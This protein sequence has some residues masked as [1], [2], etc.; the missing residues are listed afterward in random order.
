M[1]S[2]EI[3]V[4]STTRAIGMMLS[5]PTT[6]TLRSDGR[7]ARMRSTTALIASATAWAASGEHRSRSHAVYAAATCG[8]ESTGTRRPTTS[9][10]MAL[11]DATPSSTGC[12]LAGPY[13]AESRPLGDEEDRVQVGRVRV[14]VGERGPGRRGE[15]QRPR[16]ARRREDPLALIR[17]RSTYG[18]G[19]NAPL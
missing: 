11:T 4:P 10:P 18:F 2:F 5:S 7:A 13:V 14:G 19:L 12:T 16:L 15:R 9:G 3:A 6:T 17:S 8:S 1:L